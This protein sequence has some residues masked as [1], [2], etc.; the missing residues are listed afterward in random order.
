MTRRVLL[1]AAL[2][3]AAIVLPGL[4]W[5]TD[6][7]LSVRSVPI[8]AQAGAEWESAPVDTNAVL[9]GLSWDDQP[10]ASAEF[11]YR[12]D[13]G[14]SEWLELPLGEE[15]GPDDAYPE[16]HGRA[17]D[18]VF[19]GEGIEAVRYRIEGSNPVAA[20]LVEPERM[21]FSARVVQGLRTLRIDLAPEAGASTTQPTIRPRSDWDT[22]GCPQAS[23]ETHGMPRV[24]LAIVHH[25]TGH[26]SDPL[27]WMRSICRYHTATQGWDDTGYNFFIAPDGTIDEGR[28]GGIDKAI[29]GGHTACFNTGSTGVALL[30]DFAGSAPSAASIRSLEQLLAWKLDVHHVDPTSRPV[31]ESLGNIKYPAGA[32]IEMNAISGHRDAQA[33]SCPGAQCYAMLPAIRS[34]VDAIGGPKIYLTGPDTLIGSSERGYSPI[35]IGLS[36]STSMSWTARIV[37]GAGNTVLQESGTGTSATIAWDGTRNGRNLAGGEYRLQVTGGGGAR[38]VDEPLILGRGFT[39]TGGV[40]ALDIERA[41]DLGLTFGCNPP[42]NDRFCPEQAVTREQAASFLARLLHLPPAA[43]SSGF[44]D[45]TTSVHREDIER[46]AALGILRGCN[47]PD[48]TQVCPK[49]TLTR[50]QMAAMLVRGLSLT[51]PDAGF[52]DTTTSVFKRDI[53]ALADSGI[54]RGCNPPT[55][56]RFCPNAPVL[57]QELASFLVRAYG[58]LD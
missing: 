10:P 26:Q 14:W 50:G 36:F 23:E 15:H 55:N 35:E 52:V 29:R 40:H 42:T 57:R 27:A 34:A 54:T 6:A 45:H 8:A 48:N 56:N 18:P 22:Q 9:I 49:E 28:A 19:L 30:G 39:D 4:R 17:S 12:D 51:G 43:S 24:R 41:A 20:E 33:T 44:T 47:P 37:D 25:T 58:L 3:A 21:G 11:Q 1:L 53:D 31:V 13:H 46:V 2:V 32:M 5:D 16:G 7:P 38:P